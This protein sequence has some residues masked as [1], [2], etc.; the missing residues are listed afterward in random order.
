MGKATRDQADPYQVMLGVSVSGVTRQGGQN[1]R[2]LADFS[3]E[4]DICTSRC[5]GPSEQ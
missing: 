5:S 2:W 3:S 1:L 4:H